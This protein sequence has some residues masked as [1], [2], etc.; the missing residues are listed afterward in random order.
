VEKGVARVGQDLID[1]SADHDVTA[2]EQG[3]EI[4]R[5]CGLSGWSNL[6]PRRLFFSYRL[7]A[8]G[9][10]SEQSEKE[11]SDEPVEKQS[12][13]HHQPWWGSKQYTSP[14]AATYRKGALETK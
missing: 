1:A 11:N 8:T 2:H 7:F 9:Q 6:G 10:L 5:R 3:D 14:S 4:G 12:P 13:L